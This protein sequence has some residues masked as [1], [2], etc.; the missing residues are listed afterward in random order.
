MT[1]PAVVEEDDLLDV[2]EG[3]TATA[4]TTFEE[5]AEE[6]DC[7]IRLPIGP[8]TTMTILK[9]QNNE[10]DRWRETRKT[11]FHER[12]STRH[13]PLEV[14]EKLRIIPLV[15]VVLLL[16]TIGDSR[17]SDVLPWKQGFHEAIT[18]MAQHSTRISSKSPPFHSNS[19]E[20]ERVTVIIHI[21]HD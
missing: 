16:P 4:T 21:D 14:K 3:A 2:G 6:E 12:E 1:N 20:S 7:R 11:T 15:V 10:H 8:L 5:E 19:C 17:R 18:I 13:I 9:T